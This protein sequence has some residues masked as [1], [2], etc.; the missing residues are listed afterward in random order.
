MVNSKHMPRVAGSVHLKSAIFAI[1]QATGCDIAQVVQTT[2]MHI[3]DASVL[4]HKMN[5]IGMEMYGLN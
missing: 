5:L 4:R 1:R 2:V 3:K